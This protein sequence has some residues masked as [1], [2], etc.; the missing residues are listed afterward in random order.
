MRFKG[1]NIL[2]PRTISTY[3]RQTSFGISLSSPRRN[4]RSPPNSPLN[5]EEY[6]DYI[7]QSKELI[8]DNTEEGQEYTQQMNVGFSDEKP[9]SMLNIPAVVNYTNFDSSQNIDLGDFLSRPVLIWSQTWTE[10]SNFS[11]SIQPWSLYFSNSAISRK[12]DNYYMLRCNL[13]IKVVVNAS[14][15]YYGATIC[16]YNPLPDFAT[17]AP[18]S[19]EELISYSQRPNFWI[20]P[21]NSQGGEMILPFIYHKAW[22]DCTDLAE[23]QRIGEL[24]FE[25]SGLLYNAN[26][27]SLQDVDIQVYAWAT[28]LELAGP[29]ASLSLQSKEMNIKEKDEY[30]HEGAISKVASAIARYTGSLTSAPLIGPYATATSTAAGAV[31]NIASIFGY[32]RTPNINDVDFF[33][34]NPLPNF[35]STDIGE[36]IE[37]LTL[38]AKNELSIDPRICGANIDDE[39]NLKSFI[40]RESYL[41][42]FTWTATRV[43]GD[44]LFNL[45]VSP[46][47]SKSISVAGEEIVIFTPMA[48]IEKMFSYWRGDIIV[49]FKFICS[50]F[51]KGRVQVTWDPQNSNW[52][53]A[54]SL[55]TTTNYTQVVDIAKDTDVEFCIPYTQPTPYLPTQL[56]EDNNNDYS[57]GGNAGTRPSGNGNFLIKV[58]NQQTSPVASANIRVLVFVRGADNLEFAGPR[59]L[60][61]KFSPYVVQS[62]EKDYEYDASSTSVRCMGVKP[63]SIDTSLNLV[64][65]GETVPTLR[66]LLHR[67]SRYSCIVGSQRAIANSQIRVMNMLPRDPLY[68]GFDPNGIHEAVGILTPSDFKY[69]FVDWSPMTWFSLCFVG[70]RGSVDYYVRPINN[71]VDVHVSIERIRT[72][73]APFLNTEELTVNP[74]S[75]PRYTARQYNGTNGLAV[76]QATVNPTCSASLPMYSQYKFMNNNPFLRTLGTSLDGSN[77]DKFEIEA[78]NVGGSTTDPL[79]TCEVYVKAGADFSFIFFRNAPVLRYYSSFPAAGT[80]P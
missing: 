12:L 27:V 28:E 15:F 70:H 3:K 21:Q 7:L 66:T 49:R 46:H 2:S 25:S 16:S 50:K 48:Y 63:S 9:G 19:G 17:T 57:S 72:G 30:Q 58:L 73:D 20:Y 34:P 47:L 55:L 59:Q 61:Q 8:L 68:P 51:H 38:D 32:T 6:S 79:I 62:Q 64:H 10:G 1:K 36:P 29:V 26:A 18:Y 78:T 65:M 24:Y 23:V 33:R 56:P 75:A 22:I 4:S 37:K 13:H 52:A 60:D 39:L 45:I 53:S 69:N 31:A 43:T 71:G 40:T 14:P 41:T 74:Y 80:Y 11:H 76:T 77:E 44:D 42:H 5:E 54:M 67:T 35:A